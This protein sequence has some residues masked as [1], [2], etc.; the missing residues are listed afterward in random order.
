MFSNKKKNSSLEIR[1]VGAGPEEEEQGHSTD[2]TLK[3]SPEHRERFTE[4][5]YLIIQKFKFKF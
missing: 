3:R 1:V 4:I 2:A 5:C